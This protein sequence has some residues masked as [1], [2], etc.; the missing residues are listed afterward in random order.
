MS[1]FSVKFAIT[2]FRKMQIYEGISSAMDTLVHRSGL[3]LRRPVRVKSAFSV[4]Q[5]GS[6][7]TFQYFV[8]EW[9]EIGAIKVTVEKRLR[10]SQISGSWS[11]LNHHRKMI[12]FW[13]MSFVLSGM[14]IFR[15]F[16]MVTILRFYLDLI[17][18]SWWPKIVT[19]RDLFWATIVAL[20]S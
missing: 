15:Q 4:E 12:K 9:V 11:K 14:V 1:Y 13:G 18:N 8:L 10:R 16:R 5:E 7:W 2:N 6:L 17:F 3:K 19:Y 20:R